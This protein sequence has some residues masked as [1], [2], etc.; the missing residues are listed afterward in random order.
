[1]SKQCFNLQFQRFFVLGWADSASLCVIE[2]MFLK[3]SRNT[4]P[5]DYKFFLLNICEKISNL[6]INWKC[7][8]K[9]LPCLKNDLATSGP[10][11]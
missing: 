5:I 1:M 6:N 10:M 4:L 2:K 8:K 7:L 3:F 11:L 9:I